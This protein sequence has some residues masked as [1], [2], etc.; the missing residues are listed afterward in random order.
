MILQAWFFKFVL[1]F[2]TVYVILLRQANM[3][4]PRG[5][6]IVIPMSVIFES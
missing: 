2:T 6:I 5:S 4:V 3:R 1:E